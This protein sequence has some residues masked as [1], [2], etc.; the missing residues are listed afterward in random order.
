[1]L[2][3]AV[4]TVRYELLI[5]QL[6]LLGP[7]IVANHVQNVRSSPSIEGNYAES[8]TVA[9]DDEV[10][11]VIRWVIWLTNPCST[12]KWNNL[13]DSVHSIT[14][15]NKSQTTWFQHLVFSSLALSQT[16]K[17][18]VKVVIMKHTVGRLLSL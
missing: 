5:W 16:S 14:E 15:S 9:W 2:G 7:P 18:K 10:F 13:L 1:M 12:C 17:A 8:V 11:N 6:D 3:Y 4:I